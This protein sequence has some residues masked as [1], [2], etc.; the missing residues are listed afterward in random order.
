M[1]SLIPLAN[2]TPI[3]SV[4]ERSAGITV[5]AYRLPSSSAK[6][7]LAVPPAQATLSVPTGY[8]F[9]DPESESATI[10]FT[11]PLAGNYA[12]NGNFLGADTN[13]NSHP[14]EILENGSP[15]FEST[16]STFGVSTAF[17]LLEFLSPGDTIA[18]EVLTGSTGCTYCDLTTGLQA[19]ITS[20]SEN[21]VPE[22]SSLFP[23]AAAAT[24]LLLRARSKR[25]RRRY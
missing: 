23:F 19:T 14:V 1:E 24:I 5:K 10:R 18:F 7:T 13:Q 22:P 20:T 8:V 25:P 6:T 9:M 4:P 16:I 3:A 12:I 21:P 2:R 11:A 15:V 17:S